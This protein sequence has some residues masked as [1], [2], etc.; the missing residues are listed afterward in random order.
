MYVNVEYWRIL[1][2]E[3]GDNYNPNMKERRKLGD[4]VHMRKKDRQILFII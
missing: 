2:N 1:E 4:T 3:K